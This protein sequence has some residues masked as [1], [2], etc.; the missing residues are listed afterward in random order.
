MQGQRGDL[1]LAP[2]SPGEIIL[3]HMDGQRE[4]AIQQSS[5]MAS[6]EAIAIGVKTQ[7]LAAACCSG[8]G[9]FILKASGRGRLMVNS[10]GAIMRYDLKPGEVRGPST[11][12]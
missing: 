9:L 1:L 6:D 11:A 8:E 4:W 5:Y 2:S 12:E 10:F 7:G 3:L